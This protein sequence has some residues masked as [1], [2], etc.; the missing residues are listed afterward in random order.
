MNAKLKLVDKLTLSYIFFS[1]FYILFG[2]QNVINPLEN[3]LKLA[4]ITGFLMVII[5]FS[6]KHH[7]L[8][9]A[10][11]WYPLFIFGVFFDLTTF[12]NRVVFHNYLDP[13]FQYLDNLIFGYQPAIIWGTK[14]DNFFFQE[15]F[16]FAY[17]SY[18]FMIPALGIYYYQKRK[19]EFERYVV[20]ISFIFIICNL[21][22]NFLPVIGGRF[23]AETLA[24]TKN[25]RYGLF[26]N[27]MAF[28]YNKTQHWGGA[29]PSSHVAVALT[30]FLSA[31]RQKLK[32]SYWL[33]IHIFILSISVVYC[34]YHYFVDIIG[35]IIY[36][37][38][39]FKLGNLLYD[40]KCLN[41]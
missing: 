37:L 26:T 4:I 34:H 22:Y 7:L 27:I 31:Q 5:L 36:A 17:F 21:T 41:V 33:L 18:Y 40:K 8:K 10:R 25:F 2:W 13:F 39:F 24:L 20:N 35:G 1:V 23:W 6:D 38:I 16:H 14:L 15:F 28:I 3:I 30:V 12:S 11:S 32:V 19:S 9:L 29:F